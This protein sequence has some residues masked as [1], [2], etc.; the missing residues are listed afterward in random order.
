MQMHQVFTTPSEMKVMN[1]DCLFLNVWTPTTDTE[2]R[3]VM[4]WIHGGGFAFGSGAQPIYQGDGLAKFGDVV[5]V[6]VNHRLNVFG[7]LHLGDV[8]GSE[9]ASSGT[10]GMQDLVLALEW[11]RDNIEGFGGD[12]GNVTIMGQ[13]GGGAKVS[14]LLSMPS[15]KGLFHKASIQSG[16]G[17]VVGR[18]EQSTEAAKK[19]LAELKIA[20]SDSAALQAVPART[21]LATAGKLGIGAP[22]PGGGGSP[23]LDGIA[24]TRD[25]FMPDAPDESNDVPIL[26]GWTKDEWTIFT[27]QEPW[28]G[29]MTETDLEGRVAAFGDQGMALLAAFKK[30]YPDYSPTYLWEQMIS[31]RVLQGTM[32]LGE[33]KAAKGGA[34]VFMWFMTWDTPVANGMYK[35]PHT[36]EIPFML[37]SFDKVRTFVGPGDDPKKLAD[38]VAGAWV[39]FAKNGN[40]DHAGIPHWPAFNATE[41]AVMEL[42]LQSR[43]VNDPLSEA[44]QIIAQIPPGTLWRA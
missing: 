7:Y 14:I 2:N 12:P 10:V 22:G 18:K 21:L 16:A 38:Q 11:V 4:V 40:P 27:A 39:A 9:F 42:N 1:E 35:S 32:A 29:T 20:E 15:A 28:F 43:V 17:I 25:P 37:Y 23:I 24:I 36:I 31:A 34:P 33:R 3:P 13:S 41:R 30:A 5:V 8:M 26:L 44:R 19:I 6:S